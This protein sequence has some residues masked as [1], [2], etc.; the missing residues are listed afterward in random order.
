MVSMDVY[1]DNMVSIGVYRDSAMSME[2][3]GGLYK[4]GTW[5]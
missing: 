4:R 3:Y 5:L 1:G 2:V